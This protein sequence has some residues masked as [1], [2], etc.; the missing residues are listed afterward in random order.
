MTPEVTLRSA[1]LPAEVRRQDMAPTADA[2]AHT[3][4]LPRT[5]RL[6]DRQFSR[7]VNLMLIVSGLA[8]LI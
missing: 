1:R 4:S 7:L 6:N 8:L 2:M 5:Y 3:I